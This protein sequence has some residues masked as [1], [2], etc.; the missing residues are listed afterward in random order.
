MEANLLTELDV[1]YRT[2]SDGSGP[3][4]LVELEVL[5]NKHHFLRVYLA[6]HLSPLLGDHIYGNRVHDVLGVKLAISPLQADCL[7]T[8]QKI[9]KPV[10]DALQVS[11]SSQVPTC[12]HLKQLTLAKFNKN[13]NLVIT[14]EPPPFFNYILKQTNLT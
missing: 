8:F 4:S 1:T 11:S 12:L 13:G 5:N 7:S 3:C 10:L 9:P 6:H 2:L 14:A